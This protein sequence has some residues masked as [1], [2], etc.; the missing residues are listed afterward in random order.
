MFF[1]WFDSE[2]PEEP[3]EVE[4]KEVRVSRQ[5]SETALVCR[6]DVEWISFQEAEVQ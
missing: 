2:E 5:K 1:S 6:S 4:T 3:E